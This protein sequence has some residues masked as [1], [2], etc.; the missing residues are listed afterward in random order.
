MRKVTKAAILPPDT[1]ES[2]RH[3]TRSKHGK[4]STMERYLEDQYEH[5]VQRPPT[6]F[7]ENTMDHQAM[8]HRVCYI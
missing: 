6:T 7:G 1:P 8:R 2:G 5:W 3:R 4:P